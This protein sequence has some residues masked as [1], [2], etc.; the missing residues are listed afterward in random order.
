M[1]DPGDKPQRDLFQSFIDNLPGVAF[2]RDT[3]GRYVYLND[4]WERNAGLPRADIIGRRVTEVFPDEVGRAILRQ[5]REVLSKRTL[6]W[7]DE[8]IATRQGVRHFMASKFPVCDSSGSVRYVGGISID[9]SDR[10]EVERALRSSERRFRTLFEENLAGVY[11][12]TVGGRILDCN[13]AFAESLGWE[14]PE[15]LRN[16]NV[17]ES[18][19][20]PEARL[21]LLDTLQREGRVSGLEFALKRR[22][23]RRLWA[24][25]H[26]RLVNEPPDPEPVI[27]GALLDV[28]ARREAECTVRRSEEKYRDLV[29]N[30][31]IFMITHDM[32]GTIISVNAFALGCLGYSDA[33][34]LVGRNLRSFLPPAGKDLFPAYIDDIRARGRVHGLMRVLAKDGAERVLAY[35]NSLRR[36]EGRPA[37]VRGVARDVTTHLVAQKALR[38]SER[39][40]RGILESIED[41]YFEVNLEGTLRFMNEGLGRMLGYPRRE[42]IGESYRKIMSEAAA[43]RVFQTFNKVY[44]TGMPSK[45]L[46]WKIRRKSGETRHVETSVSLIRDEDGRAS[47]FRGIIRDVTERKLE[48]MRRRRLEAGLQRARTMETIGVLAQGIAHEVRNPLFA[49]RVNAAALGREA[50][51]SG[52]ASE[53]LANIQTHVKRLDGLMRDIIELSRRPG[54]GDGRVGEIVSAAIEAVER[55]DPGAGRRLVLAPFADDVQVAGIPEQIS[56][57]LFHVVLN[58]LQS[59]GPD[60]DVR[61]DFAVEDGTVTIEVVDAG[62]GIEPKMEGRLFEP[63]V[64]SHKGRRGLGLALARHFVEAHGGLLTGENNPAGP[65]ATFRIR[66][67]RLPR[68]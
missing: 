30:A 42:L 26:A 61:V 39:R 24:L 52:R 37:I 35:N 67:R 16:A 2:V 8:A 44:R 9:I 11:K 43:S 54:Q 27:F 47:G 62:T 10:L 63:F 50:C 31:E 58:A 20:D 41:G 51:T 15:A 32:S 40:Y 29:E 66:L 59:S 25:I 33:S 18:Y 34:E 5:D 64:T 19:E 6:T 21:E 65:G 13:A 14:S 55:E 56:Q 7:R 22:D 46:N 12:T 38:E 1:R 48:E 36:E 4:E 3:H 23:G 17:W 57:A 45:V 28:T 68:E 60:K 49:L 53:F